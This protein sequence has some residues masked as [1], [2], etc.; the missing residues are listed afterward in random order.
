MLAG[1]KMN[2][3]LLVNEVVFGSLTIL[4]LIYSRPHW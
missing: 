2:N 4:E 3:G 1:T